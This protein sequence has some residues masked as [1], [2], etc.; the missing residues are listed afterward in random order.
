MDDEVQ[1]VDD[2]LLSR[3]YSRYRNIF[4]CFPPE[5]QE[6]TQVQV[7]AIHALLERGSAPYADFAVWVPYANRTHKKAKLTAMQFTSSG[8]L[9]PIELHGP[10]C[11][12]S[13]EASDA[14]LKTSLIMLDAVSLGKLEQYHTLMKE[15][16]SRFPSHWSMVY[17]AD[18]RARSELMDRTKRELE[19]QRARALQNNLNHP[20]DPKRPYGIRFGQMFAPTRHGG[21]NTSTFLT[22][23][24]PVAQPPQLGSQGVKRARPVKQH[25][26]RDG[27]FV[28][29]R[30]GVPLCV[31]FQE[32]SCSG[33]GRDNRCPMDPSLAY[34]CSRCLGVGHGAL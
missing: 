4:G 6:A 20:F 28:V 27:G 12:D 5:G 32:G 9:L 23:E 29:N 3:C 26:V 25:E 7:S 18:C 16:A 34:Q 31:A 30:R 33:G 8:A 2:G 15:Y 13:W 21:N 22:G 24:A 14:V 11:F 10:A 17:Q 19:E 1:I